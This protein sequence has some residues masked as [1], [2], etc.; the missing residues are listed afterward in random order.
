MPRAALADVG[1]VTPGRGWPGLTATIPFLCLFWPLEAWVARAWRRGKE[2]TIHQRDGS[3]R[4]IFNLPSS[5]LAE[6]RRRQGC[7]IRGLRHHLLPFLFS[8]KGK[9]LT[10]QPMP[11]STCFRGLSIAQV[12]S[13]HA[14]LGTGSTIYYFICSDYTTSSGTDNT[15]P[16]K[17]SHYP[18]PHLL[19]IKAD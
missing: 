7:D 10:D 3:H 8:I 18:A 6:G 19:I 15:T 4:S 17:Y 9:E 12:P 2:M 5:G 13:P 16:P 1:R 14:I 11:V